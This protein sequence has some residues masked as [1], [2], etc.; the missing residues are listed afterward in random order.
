ML[1]KINSQKEPATKKPTSDIAIKRDPV[2][3]A[4][5]NSRVLNCINGLG[6]FIEKVELTPQVILSLFN[7]QRTLETA[8]EDYDRLKKALI[9]KWAERDS[10][11]NPRREEN[12]RYIWIASDE[13]VDADFEASQNF[14]ILVEAIL[15]TDIMTVEEWNTTER[16]DLGSIIVGLGPLFVRNV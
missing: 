3:V 12:G 11:G 2:M 5:P 8:Y 9:K 7:T 13:E 10:K 6:P 1:K 16:T 4:I 14:E 15:A